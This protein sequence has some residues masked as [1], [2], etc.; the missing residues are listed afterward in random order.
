MV[1]VTG[2]HI[3]AAFPLSFSTQIFL[4][5]LLCDYSFH[6]AFAWAQLDLNVHQSWL[7]VRLLRGLPLAFQGAAD[8]CFYHPPTSSALLS[9]G[10]VARSATREGAY[11]TSG[12]WSILCLLW[13]SS[14]SWE[15]KPTYRHTRSQKW[16]D[17][18]TL[19]CEG[20][21]LSRLMEL[22]L[23]LFLLFLYLC[24]LEMSFDFSVLQFPI[25][26]NR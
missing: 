25:L 3:S 16:R 18:N 6:S 2:S 22:S 17:N 9:A 11:T 7:D 19:S 26:L 14:R 1:R 23:R 20:Q 12:Q 21:R 5:V 13:L 4:L 10:E 15:S 8:C 24:G